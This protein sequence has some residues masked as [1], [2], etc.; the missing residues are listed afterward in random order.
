MGSPVGSILVGP[1]KTIEKA[2]QIR[3]SFG[4]GWRQAGLLASACTYVMD[5][6]W[7]RM[8][9]DHKNAAK[10]A[11]GLVQMG[12]KVVPPHTNIIYAD[13]SSISSEKFSTI[14]E[15]LEKEHSI[16]IS[17]YG[18]SATRIVVH[19]QV[20]SEHIDHFLKSFSAIHSSL[21]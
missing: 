11:E 1:A 17:G 19:L 14:K 10:L 13:F 20:T 8:E 2:K 16:L 4:G 7:Q 21:K 12:F 3:K 9:E 15:R 5:H 18:A 6:H